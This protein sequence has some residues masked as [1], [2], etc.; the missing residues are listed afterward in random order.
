MKRWYGK[1]LILLVLVTSCDLIRMKD[2][3]EDVEG[4][5][6][7]ARVYDQYLYAGDLEGIAS[8]EMTPEDSA[9][10]AQNFIDSWIRKQLLIHEA[11]ENIQFN[12][13]DIERKILDYRYSLM[14]YEYQ[15]YYINENLN[16]EVSEDE[17]KAYYDENVDNFLLKQNIIRCKYVKLPVTAPRPERVSSWLK[18]TKTEDFEELNSYCLSFANAY[19]LDDSVWMEFDEVIKNSPMA[20]IPNKVQFLRNNRY[21]ETGDDQFRYFLKIEEYKISDNVSPLEFV[22]DDIRNIILNKRK[23]TLAE[24]LEEKVYNEASEN[25][26]FEIFK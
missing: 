5:E 6:P 26:Q 3:P 12:E 15:T 24:Q 25:E 2:K 22:K 17:I 7:I 20:E 14:G 9:T 13:A 21:F 8:S 16:T 23:V 19:Q 11:S 1:G 18:S 10:R 4:Q